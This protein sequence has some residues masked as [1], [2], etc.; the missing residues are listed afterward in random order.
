MSV[1]QWTQSLAAF[2]SAAAVVAAGLFAAFKYKTQRQSYPRVE[3]QTDVA[4]VGRQHNFWF[5]QLRA[6][7]RNIGLVRVEFPEATYSL[8]CVYAE[9]R[10]EDAENGEILYRAEFPHRMIEGGNWL[11]ATSSVNYNF[12]FLEPGTSCDLYQDVLIPTRTT[13]VCLESFFLYTLGD[14]SSE[15]DGQR[16]VFRVPHQEEWKTARSEADRLG[17]S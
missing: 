3:I 10:F 4:F 6:N 15:G 16:R 9:D 14:L 13:F 11:N 5:A 8:S 2:G 12:A 1:S 7:L 17:A